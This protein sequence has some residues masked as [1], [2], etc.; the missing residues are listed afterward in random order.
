M[1]S[2]LRW[3]A[4]R[5]ILMFHNCE[6]QSHKTVSTDHNFWRERRAKADW[7]RSPSAYQPNTLLLGQTGSLVWLKSVLFLN[8]IIIH[9]SWWV[10]SITTAV[11][12]KLDF[13]CSLVSVWSN[14]AEEGTL[15]SYSVFLC[16]SCYVHS[17]MLFI[18]NCI[19][20]SMTIM[21]VIYWG[22]SYICLT[23]RN[24]FLKVQ[25][26]VTCIVFSWGMLQQQQQLKS[27]CMII[28]SKLH[29][30]LLQR[31][32][33]RRESRSSRGLLPIVW[34][35]QNWTGWIRLKMR[36]RPSSER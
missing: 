18:V 23:L 24:A 31:L 1:T 2:A 16:Y 10:S 32:Q 20:T 30:C 7:H 29:P 5:A 27:L 4:M 33:W 3:A 13:F 22:R 36:T 35:P 6:G 11:R 28:S 19:V 34:A 26:Q 15:S 17:I 12:N 21:M 8:M 25:Y 9:H 14:N